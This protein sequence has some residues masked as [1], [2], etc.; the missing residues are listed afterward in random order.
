[1]IRNCHLCWG[2]L[3]GTGLLLT[4]PSDMWIPCVV[5]LSQ[6]FL[7]ETFVIFWARI[8][9]LVVRFHNVANTLV[10]FERLLKCCVYLLVQFTRW[11]IS[12]EIFRIMLPV[13]NNLPARQHVLTAGMVFPVSHAT[14]Y[15]VKLSCPLATFRRYY[16]I[17]VFGYISSVDVDVVTVGIAC[18]VVH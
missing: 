6:C 18:V 2:Y 15:V 17:A 9:R 5:C 4:T 16:S 14:Q 11:Q 10:E 12:W 3:I 1:M 7:V 13:S 8:V